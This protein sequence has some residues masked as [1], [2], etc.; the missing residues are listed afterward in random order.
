LVEAAFGRATKTKKKKQSSA[1]QQQLSK[2]QDYCP[3]EIYIC[4]VISYPAE[5]VSFQVMHPD[6]DPEIEGVRRVAISVD[7]N[8][9][10]RIFPHDHVRF[11]NKLK[12]FKRRADDEQNK[13]KKPK[14]NIQRPKSEL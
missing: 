10:A 11:L 1:T 12:N 3:T 14:V 9:F 5:A 8:N 2:L 7:N 4:M 6:P 13:N